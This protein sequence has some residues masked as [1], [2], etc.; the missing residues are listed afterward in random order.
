[1]EDK[2]PGQFELNDQDQVVI[3]ISG[4]LVEDFFN[5]SDQ[6]TSGITKELDQEIADYII[7]SMR[8]IGENKFI[9]RITLPE[10]ADEKDISRLQD[11]IQS[12]FNNLKDLENRSIETML[13]RSFK[14]FGLGLGLMFF[15]I[16]FNRF[17]P[18]S[19]RGLTRLFYEGLTI[20]AWIPLWVAIVTIIIKW[21]PHK[22]NIRLYEK[23]IKAQVIFRH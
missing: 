15:A 5:K 12:Y 10:M 17:F 3:D 1:M 18:V 13:S 16:V 4:K 14:L 2:I 6:N 7:D 19:E 22:E 20:S 8:E 9:I 23:L 11:S 21:P